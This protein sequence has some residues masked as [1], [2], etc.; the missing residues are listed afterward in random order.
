ML[1]D[2]MES[3]VTGRR[4]DLPQGCYAQRTYDELVIGRRGPVVCGA[5]ELSLENDRK[6]IVI[7]GRTSHLKLGEKSSFVAEFVDENIF[8]EEKH[9]FFE[10]KHY[11]K[12][13]DYDKIENGLVLRHPEEGDYFV[14]DQKGGKKKLSRYY[15][16][17]KIPKDQR[18]LSLVIADGSHVV[19][20]LPD[21]LSEY[22]KVTEDTRKVLRISREGEGVPV[23]KELR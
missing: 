2:L 1:I 8:N 5:P 9:T 22:Y 4:I 21:R 23:G 12:F 17:K 16:D 18:A 19:W 14:L 15:I 6:A 3:E 20:A 11:T 10:E 7:P 13:I